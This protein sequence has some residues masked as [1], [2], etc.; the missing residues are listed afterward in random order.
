[1]LRYINLQKLISECDSLKIIMI[2]NII[3]SSFCLTHRIT[4]INRLN[5]FFLISSIT[6]VTISFDRVMYSVGENAGTVQI[7]AL[8]IQGELQRSVEIL[9]STQSGTATFKDPIDF[10]SLQGVV[11]QFD[12][13]MLQNEIL[14]TI[15]NDNIF[16]GEEIFFASLVT[17]DADVDFGN[18]NATITIVDDVDGK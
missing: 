7:S 6:G 2:V 10:Q 16:E 15:I 5:F 12:D 18:N 11:L 8:L 1:M 4:Q 3:S 13:I 17:N 14:V 9:F